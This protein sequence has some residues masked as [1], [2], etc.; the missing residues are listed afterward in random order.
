MQ[1]VRKKLNAKGK[2][3]DFERED[4][5]LRLLNQLRHPNII[6]LWGSYT[7]REE[8]NFLFPYIDMDLGKF[9]LGKSRHQ[10]FQW[11]YTFYSALAGLSSALSKTH[12][13]HLNQ[14]DHDVDF[15]AIGY[16]HDLRPPNVL[17][18]ADTFVLADFGLGS[19][20]WAE[21]QSHTPYKSISGDYIAPE[22]TDMNENPQTVNRAIDIWAFGCL[23]AEVV[24][25]MLRGAEGVEEFRVKRLTP[26]RFPQWKDASFYQPHGDAKKEV[27]IWME[28]LR[29]DHP[30][31][32]LVPRLIDVSLDALQANPQKRPDMNTTYQR[33]ATLSMQKHFRS[34][35]DMFGKVQ[36]TEVVS[37]N[38]T[39][40]HLECFRF[41][42]E[43]FGVWGRILALSDDDASH[44]AYE[45]SETCVGIMKRLLCTLKDEPKKRSLGDSSALLS[46]QQLTVSTVEELWTSLPDGLLQAAKNHWNEEFS[47][48]EFHEQ[49]W[50]PNSVAHFDQ[51]NAKPVT[52]TSALESEFEEAARLFKESLP[53]SIP[54]NEIGNITSIDDVYD[55]TDKIQTEQHKHGGLRNLPKIRLYLK[56]LQEYTTIISEEIH[57]NRD[58][59]SLL[60]GSIALLLQWAR[61]L[62]EAY[63]SVVSAIAEIGKKLPDFQAS[64]SMINRNIETMEITVLFFKDLLTF[65]REALQP[66]AHHSK[67]HHKLRVLACSMSNYFQ[68]S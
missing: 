60:W 4:R 43:R 8:Q 55:I 21:E 62:D 53:S 19:L 37:A 38:V 25:Y 35:R 18:C 7:H 41:A 27:I 67:Y 34:V 28:A 6:P 11:D 23:I 61:T 32:D 36:G 68:L 1:V 40:R 9:L 57:G 26:G 13:L 48:R 65:Y 46:L 59:L 16:H 58:V 10:D 5:C 22:C 66:F 30:H 3:K 56:R 29:R 52:Y 45:L 64:A 14:A 44:C 42:Q 33:L 50:G 17:V 20:R 51:P 54:L 47:N 49:S 63:D 2:T 12:R 31:P 24:T 39:Q 15:E